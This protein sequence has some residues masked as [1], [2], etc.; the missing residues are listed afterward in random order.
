MRFPVRRIGEGPA[1]WIAA[2]SGALLPLGFAPFG[3]HWVI[4]L[5]LVVLWTLWQ[6]RDPW[7]AA[8]F[9]FAWGAGAFLTGTYWLYI[10]IHIFGQAPVF[11]AVLLMLGL[12]GVMALYPALT[13][14]A[15]VRWTPPGLS[16]WLLVLP[17]A[18]TISEW[19]RGWLFSGFPWLS[20]GYGMTDGPL[21]G[22]APVVGV[23]GVSLATALLTGCLMGLVF[24]PHRGRMICAVLV[25]GLVLGGQTLAMAEWT[26]PADRPLRIA[27]I[28]GAVPQD[29]KW[30]PEQREPTKDLYM[31][32]TR[33][34]LDRDLLIWPE[35]AIPA[36]VS[37]EIGY[38]EMLSAEARQAGATVIL[39]MLEQDPVDGRYFNS[40]L[41]LGE[42]PAVYRKRHL[43]PFG[44]Y[45]PVPDFV[46]E[47]MRL[48]SLPYADITP[49]PRRQPPLLAAGEL[50]APSI[51]YEDAF[52]AE[53]LAFLP[54]A[55]LLLNV[56]NDAWFGN[57]IAPHQHLQIARMRSLETGRYMLRATNTGVSAVIAPDGTIIERSPQF[58]THVL[59][60]EIW[61][62]TGATP[63]IRIGNA[64]VVVLAILMLAGAVPR[65]RT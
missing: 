63:Y 11:L 62:V 17:A 37:E 6:D 15:V 27:M 30:L 22:F 1:Q 45:F 39:G 19:L 18:W 50:A 12:V 16:R 55:G 53:Q 36:I 41:T 56:S 64:G 47:W 31:Q 52:G 8:R 26:R 29:R 9:G 3:F 33:E 48:L 65:R 4:P 24:G 60:A 25:A 5:S 34:H 28:Q 57:S 7:I 44:E 35:A 61:P 10:S 20:L 43:V 42:R 58:E 21:R 23:H 32:L 14:Y 54:E 49:G 2:L 40:L 46:R 38:L 59:T 51:C 13:G